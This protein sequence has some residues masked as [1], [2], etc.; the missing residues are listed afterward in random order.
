MGFEEKKKDKGGTATMA[1]I[2]IGKAGEDVDSALISHYES[3][4]YEFEA[5]TRGKIAMVM[6]RDQAIALH[7]STVELHRSKMRD[8]RKVD[9]SGTGAIA[10]KDETT[11]VQMKPSD[12]VSTLEDIEI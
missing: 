2:S 12:F 3:L 4:G 1:R 8:A 9:L 10:T 6:P 7:E 11:S 5:E